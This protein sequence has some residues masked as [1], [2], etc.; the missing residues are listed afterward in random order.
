MTSDILAYRDEVERRA[1][2]VLDN[3]KGDIDEAIKQATDRSHIAYRPMDV[4]MWVDVVK[5]LKVEKEK[6]Q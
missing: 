5:V 2:N 1:H 3:T 4:R 6:R